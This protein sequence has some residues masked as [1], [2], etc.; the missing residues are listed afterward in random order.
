MRDLSIRGTE[1]NLTGL[2]L[3]PVV[4]SKPISSPYSTSSSSMLPSSTTCWFG[5]FSV[6]FL[7]LLTPRS[8]SCRDDGWKAFMALFLQSIQPIIPDPGS[9]KAKRSSP[10]SSVEHKGIPSAFVEE[11]E[12]LRTRVEEL[13]NEVSLSFAPRTTVTEAKTYLDHLLQRAKLK[14]ELSTQIAEVNVQ[15]ALPSSLSM[16]LSVSFLFYPPS[17]E[18]AYQHNNCL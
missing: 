14:D 12:T 4:N 8:C 17:S 11:I 3:L 16:S 10:S 5:R 2:P 6:S 15:R 13:S 9:F 7:L 1:V 18:A